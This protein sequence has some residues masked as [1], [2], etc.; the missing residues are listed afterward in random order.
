M[1]QALGDRPLVL[2]AVDWSDDEIS[3][4]EPALRDALAELVQGTP[5]EG[6]SWLPPRERLG[7]LAIVCSAFLNEPA[8]AP[9]GGT[10]DIPGL[11]EERLTPRAGEFAE[12]FAGALREEGLLGEH[13]QL[14]E[15][16]AGALAYAFGAGAKFGHV[17]TLAQM[18]E[19]GMNV[20]WAPPG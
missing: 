5:A 7:V 8:P 2:V 13:D 14:E 15:W 4:V 6:M 9:S 20:H 16:I 17:E 11:T 12:G 18:I 10:V 19:S 1:R 3:N